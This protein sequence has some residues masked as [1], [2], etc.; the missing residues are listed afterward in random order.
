[1]KEFNVLSHVGADPEFAF[2]DIL[3][4]RFVPAHSLGVPSR[5]EKEKVG[6]RVFRDGFSVELNP[7]PWQCIGLGTQQIARLLR[8]TERKYGD[9]RYVLRAPASLDL[10]V[11]AAL[12]LNPPVDVLGVGC[13]P[14]FNAYE[15]WGQALTAPW[16]PLE[17]GLRMF[18][19]HLHFSSL[20]AHDPKMVMSRLRA[21]DIAVG[22][23]LTYIFQD[24]PEVFARRRFYGRAGEYRLQRYPDAIGLEYRTPDATLFRHPA[25]AALFIAIA[26][27]CIESPE[28]VH[29]IVREHLGAVEGELDR[30]VQ[31]AINTGRGLEELLLPRYFHGFT[32][33]VPRIES[34]QSVVEWGQRYD[35]VEAELWKN[36]GVSEIFPQVSFVKH[37]RECAQRMADWTKANPKPNFLYSGATTGWASGEAMKVLRRLRAENFG[38][39]IEPLTLPPFSIAMDGHFHNSWPQYPLAVWSGEFDGV[40]V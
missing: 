11:E 4:K 5:E 29:N 26:R 15:E 19:G 21:L 16:N 1:M 36:R 6:G 9:N 13:S 23:P 22:L 27:E 39:E 37:S 7:H 35:S 34:H 8:D 14:F 3:E 38:P 40:E 24:E 12:G 32:C 10:S 17:M 25:L 28:R 20:D 31:I 18:S 30:A 2:F 33:R